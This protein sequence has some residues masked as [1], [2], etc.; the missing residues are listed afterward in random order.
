MKETE[1]QNDIQKTAKQTIH[2]T[3]LLFGALLVVAT[4]INTGRW[5]YETFYQPICR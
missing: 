4:V 1:N 3:M 5:F 2:I